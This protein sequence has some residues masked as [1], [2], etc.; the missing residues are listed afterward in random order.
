MNDTNDKAVNAKQIAYQALKK[1]DS[2]M[3]ESYDSPRRR[4]DIFFRIAITFMCL[5]MILYMTINFLMQGM[6]LHY[7][8]LD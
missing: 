5:S 3:S 6:D 1:N 2:S 4:L 7:S 8:Q